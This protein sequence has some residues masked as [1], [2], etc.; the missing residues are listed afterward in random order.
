MPARPD[1]EPLNRGPVMGELIASDR[2]LLLDSLGL[3]A[4]NTPFSFMRAVKAKVTNRRIKTLT[5]RL[6]GSYGPIR[7][8][9]PPRPMRP[10]GALSRE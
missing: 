9:R 5:A 8:D 2:G 3:G 1:A 10:A 6:A 7:A 4:D